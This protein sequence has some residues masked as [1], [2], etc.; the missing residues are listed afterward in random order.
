MTVWYKNLNGTLCKFKETRESEDIEYTHNTERGVCMFT[1]SECRAAKVILE[2]SKDGVSVQRSYKNRVYILNEYGE[3][4]FELKKDS[5]PS[6]G[7]G[8]TWR[9]KD[10]AEGKV[11]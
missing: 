5:F 10:I 6:V 8:E 2:C 9:L 3:I 4:S 1:K 7:A 11:K